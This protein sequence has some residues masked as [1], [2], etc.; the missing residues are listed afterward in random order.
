MGLSVRR[1]VAN[2]SKPLLWL[3]AA[4]VGTGMALLSRSCGAATDS[5]TLAAFWQL[6]S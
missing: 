5:A 6:F 2:Y 4:A 3:S 1:L